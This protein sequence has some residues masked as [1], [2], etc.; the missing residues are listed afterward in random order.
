[1]AKF[2]LKQ[3]NI[4]IR[5]GYQKLGA[6]NN[7]AG[8]TTGAT[9]ITVDGFTGAVV[10]GMIFYIGTG[11]TKYTI[12]SHVE[13]TGNT[14]SI[15]F[16]PPI[17][18]GVTVADNDIV[19]VG[20][21]ELVVKVG[22]GN[23]SYTEKKAR[24]YVS[25][26]GKLDTVRDGDEAPVEVKLDFTWEWI[27]ATTGQTPTIED[28]L[29]KRG[30]ASTWVSSSSDQCEPYAVDIII[31]YIPP[32][33]AEDY[34]VITLPDYRYEQIDHDAKAGTLSTQGKCNTTEA[35]PTRVARVA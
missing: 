28:V 12:A 13:T 11:V 33:G 29:K 1:M 2:D 21:H 8:Y 16:T 19:T 31:E 18:T 30:N 25:D 15:T 20:P 32:C 4:Y 7:V 27:K 9:T 6:V 3:A 5:D 23:L 10:T 17:P 34:E 35:I 24:E 22:E 26:R 14:T